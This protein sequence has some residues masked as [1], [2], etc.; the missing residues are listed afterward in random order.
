LRHAFFLFLQEQKGRTNGKNEEFYR[1]LS[2]KIDKISDGL[3]EHSRLLKQLKDQ[4]KENNKHGGAI[5][6]TP[7]VVSISACFI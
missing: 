5:D 6:L 7:W 2:T 4:M 1:R 3:D